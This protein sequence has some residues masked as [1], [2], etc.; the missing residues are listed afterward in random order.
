MKNTKI[1]LY[2]ILFK[3]G[4][5]FNGGY[6]LFNTEWKNIPNKEIK[7][8]YYRLPAG[9]YLCLGGYEK[10][11]HRVEAIVDIS[12]KEKGKT[13]LQSIYLYGKKQDKV[14][15]YQI[16]LVKDINLGLIYK[17]IVNI[18]DEEIKKL[19]PKNWK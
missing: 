17:K 3:D 4:T 8:L 15:V 12:G 13:K 5:I 18:N 19:N 14:I 6:D 2:K 16:G 1:S 7:K 9:D 11:F 10:Y